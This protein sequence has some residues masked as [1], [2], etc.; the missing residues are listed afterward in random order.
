MRPSLAV[1]LATLLAALAA[2]AALAQPEASCQ[3]RLSGAIT[4]A[5]ACKASL[6]SDG[7]KV[8]VE[9]LPEG[10]VPGV[11]TFVPATFEFAAPPRMGR[12]GREALRGPTRIITMAGQS[13]EASP[14]EGDVTLNLE[15]IEREQQG[16]YN[17]TGTLQAR[18]MP[19]FGPSGAAS[20]SPP[21]AVVLDVK[22]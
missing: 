20:L 3:G 7:K 4:A 13:F 12:F 5:F 18:L 14:T 6:S 2:P 17:L 22:F 9:I 8:V 10:A 15:Q 11:K 16:F 21:G 19:L 1:S